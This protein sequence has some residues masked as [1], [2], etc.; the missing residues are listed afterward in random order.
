M[1]ETLALELPKELT[2]L[3][4]EQQSLFA[5]RGRV[6]VLLFWNASSV[7]C[8]NA[9]LELAQLQR[10]FPNALSAI[11]I[12]IPK[13]T[14][15]LDDRIVMDM[16]DRLDIQLPVANDKNCISW[17]D[18]EIISWPTFVIIDSNGKLIHKVL[19]DM[20]YKNI[21]AKVAALISQVA[22]D[23]SNK[24]KALKCNPK[25]KSF[26]ILNNPCGLFIHKGLLYISDTGN[27]RVL[28][29]S[30][31][32]HV[33]R[34]FGNGLALNMDGPS[35]ESAFCRPLGLCLAREYLYVA[36]SGNHSIRRIRLLDG[37]VDTLLGNGTPGRACDQIVSDYHHV[38]F[39][40]PTSVN[41]CQ[42]IL[43][44]A[45]SG[46]NCLWMYNLV[47]RKFNLLVGSGELGLI[48]GLGAKVEMAHPLSIT[49]SKN[50]LYIAEGSSSSIR[51]VSVPE[52]N[53]NTLVGHGLFQFG[54]EDGGFQTANLQHPSCLVL[55]DK[56]GILWIAD[57]YNRKI[58]TYDIANNQLS[59]STIAANFLNPCAIAKDEESIW[60]ADSISN[61]IYRYYIATDYLTRVTIQD[62]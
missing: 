11:A 50:C 20:Q 38:Q 55:D 35:A 17:Q 48:D 42:D 46:N 27:N 19:G 13:F 49:G 44:L 12:H 28:E 61:T 32:G 39:N 52:G 34:I 33:K 6:V 7:Y 14:A 40:N 60:I 51:T 4:A 59:S 26:Q 10:K 58:R 24:P 31:D 25:N 30:T 5:H 18:Y 43:V 22:E 47:S 36:D 37:Y 15:E 41:V 54:S 3:N 16:Y 23:L 56:H 29:C 8:H 45:D 9:L 53:I 2:W 1:D 57:S 62:N 21:E